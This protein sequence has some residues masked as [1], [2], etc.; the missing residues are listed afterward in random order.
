MN[1]KT[2]VER[3]E[4]RLEGKGEKRFAFLREDGRYS[5]EGK[6]LTKEELALKENVVVLRVTRGESLDDYIQKIEKERGLR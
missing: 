4:K 6:T 5:C 2:K 1:T 3:L